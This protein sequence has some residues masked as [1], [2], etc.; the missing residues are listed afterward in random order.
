MMTRSVRF[1]GALAA[2]IVA[3]MLLTPA[4]SF[5]DD[6][7]SLQKSANPGHLEEPGNV[8]YTYRVTNITNNPVPDGPN[9]LILINVE[10]TDS[11]LGTIEGPPSGDNGNER[12]D[13]GETWVYTE[14]VRISQDT[15]NSAVVQAEWY[16]YDERF[17]TASASATVTVGAAVVTPPVE[18]DVGGAIPTTGTPWYNVLLIGGALIVI[19]VAGASVATRRRHA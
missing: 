2:V 6:A 10:L 19:G 11:K 18:T 9:N 8:T 12:L 16:E 1:I 4:L 3:A 14:T 5:A 13:P 15:T 7:I 17:A